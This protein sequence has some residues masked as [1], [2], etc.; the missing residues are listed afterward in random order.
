MWNEKVILIQKEISFK[1][2]KPVDNVLIGSSKNVEAKTNEKKNKTGRVKSD[3]EF[4]ISITFIYIFFVC[5]AE[6]VWLNKRQLTHV[7]LC[8]VQTLLDICLESVCVSVYRYFCV[9]IKVCIGSIAANV[10]RNYCTRRI[11]NETKKKLCV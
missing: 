1:S 4:G 5:N 7:Y 6:N 8:S 3:E 10:I 11:R 2:K 9:L